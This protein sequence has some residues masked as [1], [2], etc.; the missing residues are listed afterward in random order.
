MRQINV[1]NPSE[2][3]LA[4]LKSRNMTIEQYARD[5]QVSAALERAV[6]GTIVRRRQP[7]PLD[8]PVLVEEVDEPYEAWST[9][10]LKT[11]LRNRALSVEGKKADLVARLEE[12]D[13]NNPQ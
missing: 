11:E 3:D 1:D 4:F 7:R 2:D 5:Q 12:D 10:E 8:Q 13:R 9:E 6:M